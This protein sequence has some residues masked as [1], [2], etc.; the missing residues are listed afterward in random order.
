MSYGSQ[1]NKSAMWEPEGAWEG[2]LES[3]GQVKGGPFFILQGS[4]DAPS[5]VRSQ[6]GAL[7]GAEALMTEEQIA[8]RLVFK[9]EL[10]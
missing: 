6:A 5:Q 4:E 8:A 10:K 3:G 1:G 2:I 9:K 7:A